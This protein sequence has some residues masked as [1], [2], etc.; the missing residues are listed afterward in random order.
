MWLILHLHT[1][2]ISQDPPSSHL[3]TYDFKAPTIHNKYIYPFL[4]SLDLSIFLLVSIH[5]HIFLGHLI[6]DILLIGQIITNCFTSIYLH[7]LISF[8]TTMFKLIKLQ[9]LLHYCLSLILNLPLFLLNIFHTSDSR[10]I[11]AFVL[12]LKF[13]VSW[14]LPVPK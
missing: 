13:S 3:P 8:I 9:L 1:S 14:K 12:P 5:F 7:L 4:E 6:L 11:I 2:T 10:T